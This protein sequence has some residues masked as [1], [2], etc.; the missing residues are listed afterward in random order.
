[1][2]RLFI[3]WRFVISIGWAKSGLWSNT[4]GSEK[5]IHI[6]SMHIL[7]QDDNSALSVIIG[8]VSLVIGLAV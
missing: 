5:R 6:A 4:C 1:M 8:P 2:K 7:Q 3:V